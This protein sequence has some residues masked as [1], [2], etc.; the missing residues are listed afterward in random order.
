[1]R[2]LGPVDVDGSASVV[3][4]ADPPN[5]CLTLSNE[6][7]NVVLVRETLSAMAEAVGVDGVDLNDIRTAVTEACNNV[8]LHAYEGDE[9][10]LQLEMYVCPDTFEIVVRDN[11]TGIRPHIRGED[12]EALGIG[13]SIIQALA[14]RVEFRDVDGGGTEVR[15]EFATPSAHALEALVRNGFN[16]PEVARTD[17]ARTTGLAVAPSSLART[18]LPRV[19]CVLAARA[20]FTTDRIADAEL[21]ADALVA[22]VSEL[23]AT[24]H[25]E[26]SV[27]V[28]PRRLQLHIGPLEDGR[29]ERLMSASALPDAGSVI[30]RLS[31][32]QRLRADG[33]ATMLELLLVDER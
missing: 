12:D 25:L 14:P 17:L 1:M 22:H 24:G 23:S 29:A 32:E 7:D 4:M 33:D 26:L 9:G 18:V 16:P 3:S 10:P 2:Q 30:E 27:S 11:G 21:L 8:V 15:M 5:V 6:P 31:D 19:I 28:D 13:L 20:R